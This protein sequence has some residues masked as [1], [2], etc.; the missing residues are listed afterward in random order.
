MPGRLVDLLKANL[1]G[2]PQSQN[3][4]IFIPKRPRK[5]MQNRLEFSIL[6]LGLGGLR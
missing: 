6:V 2:S 5:G 1:G 4:D 3:R